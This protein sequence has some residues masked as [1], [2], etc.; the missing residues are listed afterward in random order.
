[1]L[2][3][4]LFLGNL[5]TAFIVALS[6]P[7]CALVAVIFMDLNGISANLM[8]LGGIAI[9]IGMLGDGAIV[10]VE[11]IYR[12]LGES[13]S[14]DLPKGT[15]ILQA[16]REVAK[17]IAFSI[18]IIILVFLPLFTLEGVEGKMFSPTALRESIRVQ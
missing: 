13:R 5:R 14:Q 3:L 16:G 9:A 10:M 4:L 17:P 1:M 12:H 7:V 8:S 18:A 6:L 11:N 2:V 15:I